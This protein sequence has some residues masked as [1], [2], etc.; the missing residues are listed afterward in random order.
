MSSTFSATGQLLDVKRT[1]DRELARLRRP[2]C[3]EALR[4]ARQALDTGK[5]DPDCLWMAAFTLMFLAGQHAAA[6]GIVDR[7]SSLN[8]NSA[9][10]WMTCGWIHAFS[11]RANSGIE[12]FERATRLS[13]RDPFAWG[14]R[15]GLAFA[16][17]IAGR[18]EEGLAYARQG[19]IEQPRSIALL[20]IKAGLCG[21]AGRVEEGREAIEELHQL[22]PSMTLTQYVSMA[23]RYIQP[24][25]LAIHV[26]GLRKAGFPE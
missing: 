4:L 22:Y 1:G 26:E 13:P 24:D 21:H 25:P 2:C 7:A 10:A 14:F 5:D 23:S 17:M 16:H 19:L 8:P 11:G 9:L 20:R 15:G 6:T 18:Y 12:A 3:E